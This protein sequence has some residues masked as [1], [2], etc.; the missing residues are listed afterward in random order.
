MNR[1]VPLVNSVFNHDV[2]FLTAVEGTSQTLALRLHC[3]N[4]SCFYR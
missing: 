4:Y 1:Y 3:S 2:K